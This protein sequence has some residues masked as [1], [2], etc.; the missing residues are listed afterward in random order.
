MVV[1]VL[2]RLKIEAKNF[3]KKCLGRF[4]PIS[5]TMVYVDKHVLKTTKGLD[6]HVLDCQHFNA[7][8]RT[9]QFELKFTLH[10]SAYVF[11]HSEHNM[12]LTLPWR[13][14]CM[15]LQSIDRYAVRCLFTKFYAATLEWSF[16][17]I[18]LIHLVYFPTFV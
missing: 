2:F 10:I 8:K 14:S 9:D 5:S 7:L 3:R 4:T 6:L 16:L 13:S 12:S 1:W 17:V 15:I 11:Q 18:R